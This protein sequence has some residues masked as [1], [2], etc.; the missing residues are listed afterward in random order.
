VTA[1]DDEVFGMI[2]AER[3]AT[4]DLVEGFAPEQLATQSLCGAWTVHQVAAH[5]TAPWAVGVRGFIGPIVRAGG[6]FD[7]ANDRVAK[8]LAEQPISAIAASLRD[9]ADHRFTPPG[10]GP[11]APL[12]DVIVHT[13]DM[14]RPLGISR[15]VA[16]ERIQVSLDL[17]ATKRANRFRSAR[18]DGL[19]FV[20]TD[21]DWSWGDGPELRGPAV[22]LA[23]AMHG[24]M[25]ATKE[26]E[27]DGVDELRRRF[28]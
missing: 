18:I 11:E 3:R 14:C 4:A 20:A 23:V 28:G 16:P 19:R 15:D 17:L 9:H 13:Q 26:L 25:D 2:A 27:G 5:L 24:R 21:Q 1:T 8:R 12:T 10:F 7:K 22:P 6:N